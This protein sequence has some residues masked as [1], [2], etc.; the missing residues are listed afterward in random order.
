MSE[1]SEKVG[2]IFDGTHAEWLALRAY[3]RKNGRYWK[4]ALRCAWATGSYRSAP[5]GTADV[6]QAMR[7]N[8]APSWLTNVNLNHRPP[9]K[10]MVE[11]AMVGGWEDCWMDEGQPCRF[12]SERE[13]HEEIEEHIKTI[14]SNGGKAEKKDFRVRKIFV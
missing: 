1:S 6:L 8:H 3:S 4:A 2:R 10:F 11:T 5:V 7:N 9:A 13:A 14:I 12:G